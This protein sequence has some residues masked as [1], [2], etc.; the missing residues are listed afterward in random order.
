MS[1]TSKD[2]RD[3][4]SLFELLDFFTTEDKCEEYL[5]VL[6][7][8]GAPECPYCESDRVNLLKGKNKRYKCYGCKKQFS[9]KVGTIFH[10]SK[11][12]L[13]KWFVAIYLVT[14]HKKGI[15]SHQLS[16]D[17]KISQKS[18][19][20]VLQR[21]RETYKPSEEK[22]TDEVEVD[23]AWVGGRESNKHYHKKVKHNKGRSLKTKIP[24]L[25]IIQRNGKVFAIPVKDTKTATIVPIMVDRVVEGS[26]L[27]T[28]EYRPYKFLANYYEH[29]FIKHKA[30]QYVDG[31]V[32]TNSIENFWSHLK[33]GINGIYH[34]VSKKHLHK[35]VNEYTFRFNNRNLSE[36]SKFD[37][38]IA[39]GVNKR[40]DYKTL[41]S[42]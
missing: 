23:E 21:I 22:F 5:A 38:A 40:L 10:D 26:K 25:G 35:Y 9:V 14:S 3:F 42:G 18:A 32:H 27:Y 8:N 34:H 16:R 17:L 12:S 2:L 39:N 41:I 33:R 15:S 37:I 28:D 29:S 20:F 4:D 31:N 6:R 7:W 19:W 30:S 1:N 11:L 13:R 36:G 24:V